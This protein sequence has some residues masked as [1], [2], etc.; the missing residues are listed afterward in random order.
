MVR[1][2]KPPSRKT[3]DAM[4]EAERREACQG[5]HH[6]FIGWKTDDDGRLYWDCAHGCG[7]RHRRDPVTE[8]ELAAEC[9]CAAYEREQ[10][11]AAK[12]AGRNAPH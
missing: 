8:E 10:Q 11:I 3:L 5:G 1:R 2:W 4:Y 6:R 9:D 7:H 12:Q